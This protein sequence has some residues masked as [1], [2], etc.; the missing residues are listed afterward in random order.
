[1]A[2]KSKEK[3]NED[4]VSGEMQTFADSSE[5]DTPVED[6]EPRPAR[7]KYRGIGGKYIRE[8]GIRIRVEN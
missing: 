7:N 1:M 2:P 6:S 5:E 3:K 8:N 4:D